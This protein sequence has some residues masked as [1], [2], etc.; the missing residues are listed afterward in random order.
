MLWPVAFLQLLYCSAHDVRLARIARK[1]K[2]TPCIFHHKTFFH[3]ATSRRMGFGYC[4]YSRPSVGPTPSLGAYQN[5]VTAWGVALIKS[6]HF[7]RASV[8]LV[9]WMVVRSNSS[10]CLPPRFVRG[11]SPMSENREISQSYLLV[12]IFTFFWP[13]HAA[14]DGLCPQNR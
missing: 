10:R 9:T 5:P 3:A 4:P 12:F 14:R 1:Q 7:C 8:G 6:M 11:V 2:L 13:L